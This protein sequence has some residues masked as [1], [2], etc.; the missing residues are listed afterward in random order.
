MQKRA[1]KWMQNMSLEWL[2][3]LVQEPKRLF[4]RY[5]VTNS[6]FLWLLF[7]AWFRIKVLKK[8]YF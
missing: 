6:L 1:P 5:F 7:K 3:R 2:F 8:Q 4:K